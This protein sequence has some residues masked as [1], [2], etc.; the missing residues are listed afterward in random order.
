MSARANEYRT[1]IQ[2]SPG[3]HVTRLS[4]VAQIPSPVGW[5]PLNEY[6][7]HRRSQSCQH[8][9][10]LTRSNAHLSEVFLIVA[11]TVKN[12]VVLDCLELKHDSPLKGQGH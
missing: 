6:L 5:N 1:R 7:L 8:Y 10:S 9:G 3:D 12:H 2:P 4:R 11:L